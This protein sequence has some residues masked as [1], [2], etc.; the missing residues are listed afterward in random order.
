MM[1]FP[2]EEILPMLAMLFVRLGVPVVLVVLMG[3]LAQRYE[4]R[5]A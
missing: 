2:A 5:L 4:Q 3:S 1:P